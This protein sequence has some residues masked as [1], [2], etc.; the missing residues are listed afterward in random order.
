MESYADL[1]DLADWLG[2]EVEELPEKSERLLQRAKYVIDY[3]TLQKAG[4][5]IAITEDIIQEVDEWEGNV[6]YEI[7]DLVIVDEVYYGCVVAHT[8]RGN[9]KPPYEYWEEIDVEELTIPTTVYITVP[10]VTKASCAQVE[11]WLMLGDEIGMTQMFN[12]IS[13]GSFSLSQSG[14]DVNKLAPMAYDL[15]MS[16]GM[17]SRGVK[18][19]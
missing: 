12:S 7:G 9:N 14:D 11:Y 8:S 3:M 13:I 17:L 10:E 16:V 18:V 19:R 4:I 5:E 2:K 15:L 6:N 1:D